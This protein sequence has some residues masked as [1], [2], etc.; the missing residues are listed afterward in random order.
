M[1]MM[2]GKK[3]KLEHNCLRAE[4]EKCAV[5]EDNVQTSEAPIRENV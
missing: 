1:Q 2:S 5:A 3:R 4:W